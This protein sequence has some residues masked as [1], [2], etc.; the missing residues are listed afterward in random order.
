MAAIIA[1]FNHKGG[2][3]KTTT[4]FNL[5][6]MLAELG[7][8]VIMVD[9]DPQC[10]LTGLTLGLQGRE[11]L[12]SFYETE[13][14]RNIRSGLAPAFE[15]KPSPIQPVQC[16]EVPQRPG[17]Y[18][19][20]GHLRLSEYEVTLGIAQQLSASLQALRNIPGAMVHLLRTTAV[21]L[22]AEFVLVDMSPSLSAINQ[23]LLMTSDYFIVPA[24]PD[25]F[26]KMA[27]QSLS[28][29][30][31]NWKKWASE[32]ANTPMLRNADYPFPEPNT[33]FVG[34]IL[35]KYRPHGGAPSAGF[36]K[37]IE[38][39]SETVTQALVPSLSAARMMLPPES[40]QAVGISGDYCLASIS[41]FNTLIARSHQHQTPVF[42][43]TPEQL[44]QGGTV[45]EASM[46]ARDK[47]KEIFVQLAT[48]VVSL[49]RS[50]NGN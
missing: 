50:A 6:W 41:D 5:G 24:S 23:N 48:R 26:S 7:S 31:P 9:T 14:N 21:E 36:Q 19:L 27:M 46:T 15:S 39:I 1:L 8:K 45:L 18:L 10:N 25:Y 28:S 22:N 33:R 42:A 47:F 38:A 4:T 17:L 3:S 30:L 43:L 11:D 37:W 29:V 16:I 20:P 34:T 13:P 12:E 40:Y 44:E 2:V 49:T 32:A 35:Q